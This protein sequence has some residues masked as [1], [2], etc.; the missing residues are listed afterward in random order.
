MT[1]EPQN[2]ATIFDV[3]R[4]AGVSIGTVSR[5]LN[6]RKE[7]SDAT[8]ERVLA[9]A[10][11]VKYMPQLTTRRVSLGVVM[12][13]IEEVH[14]VGYIGAV[15]CELANQAARRGAVLE[16]VPLRDIERIY[17]HYLQ[18]LI[19]ILFGDAAE[20]LK[21]ITHIPVFLINNMP[22]K[23]AFHVA[24]TDHAQGARMGA[25]YLLERGHRRIAL[26]QIEKDDW[27]A[28]ERERGF[29]EAFKQAG[30]PVPEDLITYLESWSVE[31][32]FDP[33]L[34]REPTAVFSCGEDLSIAITDA[35]VHRMRLKIP[36]DLSLLGYEV[37]LV[38][39]ML[40]P[41]QTT[42]AQPWTD[43]ARAAVD[44]ILAAIKAPPRRPQH[45]I[46]PNKLIERDSVRAMG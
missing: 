34:Q 10:K 12:R 14:E 1:K 33:V 18:G 2:K 8:R 21:G 3:A 26:V 19:G 11:R 41:P 13:E 27:G 15:I 6:N 7:V 30:V 20:A 28:S 37:P 4:E 40:T 25:G 9:A 5:V 24:A 22:K 42:V 29:R 46:L 39:R 35:L 45:I 31:K 43:L 36:D 23:S 44:G 16:L 32:A 17:Q 38:S